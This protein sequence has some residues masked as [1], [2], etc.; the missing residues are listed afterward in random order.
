MSMV[1]AVTILNDL[2]HTANDVT[3]TAS[4]ATPA[5]NNNTP[6]TAS[7]T[8]NANHVKINANITGTYMIGKSGTK[9]N[10]V[11]IDGN[12]FTVQCIKV[13]GSYVT[14]KNFIVENCE[15]HAILVLGNSVIVENNTVR[16]NVT[17]NGRVNCGALDVQWG[18]GIKTERGSHDV[19]IRGNTVYENCGEGIASTMS[20]NVLIE[21][22]TAWD[23]F[24][25][26]IYVDN[27]YNVTVLNNVVYCTGIYLRNGKRPTGIVFAEESYMGWG[28]QRHDNSAI[29]NRVNGCDAGIASWDS[30]LPTG[31]EIRLLIEGNRIFDTIGHSIELNTVNEDVVIR[32]NISNKPVFV[33]QPAGS[34]VTGNIK[35]TP[36]PS[37]P[38][39][40]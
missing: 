27:S 15:S 30:E 25:V 32:N 37:L 2:R 6:T 29:N 24:S 7:A 14:V 33:H 39:I 31:R 23:N 20:Y 8:P 19:I 26:Q 34:I 22:N 5:A 16:F 18:S 11:I 36:T 12:G 3:P 1:F 9:I 4:N 28:T 40:P 17:E 35:V 13:T 21:N 38:A 10:P